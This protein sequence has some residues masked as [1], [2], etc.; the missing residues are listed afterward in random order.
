[1]WALALIAGLAFATLAWAIAEA[2]AIPETGVITGGAVEVSASVA[3]IRNG[4]M[5]YGLLGG[6][7]A[8]GLGLAGGLTRRSTLWAAL[9][10][11]IGVILGCVAAAA[12]AQ[13]I[14]PRYYAK[15]TSNDLTDSLLVHGAI[16]GALGAA[17]GLAFGVGLGGWRRTIRTTLAA[18]GAALVATAIYE[19]A[20]GILAPQAMTDR[21][22]AVTAQVRLMA[23][24]LLAASVVIGAALVAGSSPA[25]RG[26]D[27][28]TN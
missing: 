12:A 16:W 9:A 21:P 15:L 4:T 18:A 17:A 6:Y 24:L 11:V 5:S 23:D 22:L 27:Q 7:L 3:G 8:L 20:G 28:R 13:F 26:M 1:M 14:L 19:I 10:L 25:T 2:L